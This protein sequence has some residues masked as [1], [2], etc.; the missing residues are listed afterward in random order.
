MPQRTVGG[1]VPEGEEVPAGGGARQGKERS[2][3]QAGVCAE[4]QAP[5]WRVCCFLG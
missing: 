5:C 3:G 2:P 4:L 1:L